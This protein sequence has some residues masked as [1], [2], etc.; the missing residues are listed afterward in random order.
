MA[1]S[2]QK[3]FKTSYFLG[4]AF[5]AISFLIY[6]LAKSQSFSNGLLSDTFFINYGLCVLYLIVL[7]LIKTNYSKPR[8]SI[9]F[10]CWINVT[11]LFTISA[12]ALNKEMKVF[13]QFPQ[14]LN[15]YTLIMIALFLIYP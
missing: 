15:I 6:I 4:L 2:P 7:S 11:V 1:N 3:S 5:I 9:P 13:A 14:W 12:F 10:E 8:P